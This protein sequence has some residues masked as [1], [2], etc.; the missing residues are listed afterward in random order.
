M[1][2]TPD[3]TPRPPS[4][5]ALP[6]YLAGHVARIG[7]DALVEAVGR[8]GLRLPHFATLTALADFGPLPQ[9]VLADRLG[10]QRSHLGGYLDL[11][12]ERGL[13]HRTRDPADRR[14][15][16]VGLTEEGTRLQRTLWQV[17]EELQ[18]SFLACFTPAERE[19]L[20][21]LLLRLLDAD[22]RARAG[23]TLDR[24]P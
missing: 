24:I 9:H 16:L 17:A 10:F 1:S 7:H 2:E 12:E 15:Q 21:A 20:T 22:D 19:T 13:V 14:R 4:L 3:S 23:E 5:L 8:H 6:S 11:I 18:D